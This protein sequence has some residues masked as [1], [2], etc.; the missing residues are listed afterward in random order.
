MPHFNKKSHSEDIKFIPPP[1][2]KRTAELHKFGRTFKSTTYSKSGRYSVAVGL[3]M[4]HA[5]TLLIKTKE[6]GVIQRELA[7][8]GF[9]AIRPG[10]VK[11]LSKRKKRIE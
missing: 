10:R 6:K 5:F 9:G 11:Y 3:G 1:L 4:L 2:K 8:Q 7:E